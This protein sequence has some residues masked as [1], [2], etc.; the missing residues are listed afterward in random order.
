MSKF[1][2]KDKL[3][4]LIY[5]TYNCISDFLFAINVQKK[6]VL[7]RNLAFKDKHKGARCFILG[8]G[9]SLNSLSVDELGIIRKEV[10]FGTNSLYK[11]D[12]TASIIPSY[13]ALLD[14]IY[15]EHRSHTFKDVANK[16]AEKPPVFITDL[17][18]KTVADEACREK[19]HV[20]IHSKKYPV[21]KMSDRLDSN[22]YAAMN[23]V[24]YSI[25]TAMYMGFKEICLLGCDY[26]AF[27]SAG[28]GHA[29]NDKSELQG[30]NYN[31]AFYLRFYWI[32][33]EFHYLIAKL[34]SSRGVE[35]I[36]LTPGSLLDAYKREEVTKYF[37]ASCA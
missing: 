21:D 2:A 25:L 17:R 7:A 26:S 23:V 8:T 10:V 22:I 30:V 14:N 20:F 4:G 18:A 5:S 33:T 29:Y 24:S 27:C 1:E 31:L 9:P 16:Y 11:A 3:D 13:Y 28:K 36:N 12:V 35:I 34:A 19:Q 32:T 6:N 15:W 37:H